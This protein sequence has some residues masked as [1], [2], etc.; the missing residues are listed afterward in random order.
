MFG[1]LALLQYI[2]SYSDG[3]KN[4]AMDKDFINPKIHQVVTNKLCAPI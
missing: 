3:S 4:Y 2:N 1:V